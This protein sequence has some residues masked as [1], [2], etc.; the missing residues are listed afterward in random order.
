M[1]SELSADASR[2]PAALVRWFSELTHEG[3]FATDRE[4]RVIVWNRWMEI[5]SERPAA[6]VIGLSLFELFPDLVHRG[7]DQYYREALA[8]R[9]AVMSFGLHKYVLPLAPTYADL[10]YAEMPQSGRIGPLVNSTIWGI[11]ALRS[12]GRPVG[13]ATVRYLLGQQR[14]SGGW[15]SITGGGSRHVL[16]YCLPT[17]WIPWL[18]LKSVRPPTANSWTSG[19][20]NS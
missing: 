20:T 8:G 6:S 2:L 3:M 18:R 4:F 15:S 14:P 9:I 5:K 19:G 17:C 13:Q 11:L 7:I 16:A 1:E 12:A 10:G